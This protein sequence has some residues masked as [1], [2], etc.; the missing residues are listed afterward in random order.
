MS[1]A[2]PRIVYHQ[3]WATTM[4][5]VFGNPSALA[6]LKKSCTKRW[7]R[8]VPMSLIYCPARMPLRFSG[9]KKDV[10]EVLWVGG[11]ELNKAA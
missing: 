4:S 9:P 11:A 6:T 1:V 2:R 8:G 3:V 5:S 10:A 7:N